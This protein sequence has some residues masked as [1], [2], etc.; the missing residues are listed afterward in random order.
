[1][2]EWDPESLI[3]V[4]LNKSEEN[5]A[6]VVLNRRILLPVDVTKSLWQQASL[7]CLVD[8][9][10]NRWHTFLQQNCSEGELKWPDFL[11][12]DFDSLQEETMTYFQENSSSDVTKI[13]NTPDQNETDFT[14]SLRVLKSS[15]ERLNV[16]NIIV[17]QEFSGRLDQIMGNIN[18]L[19]KCG[20]ILDNH[21]LFLL[22]SCSMTW[23]LKPGQ[24]SIQIPKELCD[25]NRWCSLLPIGDKSVVTS[26]GL[27]WNLHNDI[28]G[29]GGMVSS[30]NSYSKEIV[31]ITTDNHIVWSMGWFSFEDD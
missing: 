24:H 10:A 1:M 2:Q 3:N 11:T 21:R 15:L 27:K 5:F 28:L 12:G 26:D 17:L 9:G 8:G 23:L 6:I 31:T 14:K 22:S 4:E 7:R 13:V 18:T 30:S 29:F 20:D 25:Q 19:Y 16:K